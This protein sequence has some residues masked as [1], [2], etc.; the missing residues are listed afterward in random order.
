MRIMCVPHT[1][2]IIASEKYHTVTSSILKCDI[3]AALCRMEIVPKLEVICL[4]WI[5]LKSTEVHSEHK[6]QRDKY[7]SKY[8]KQ[9]E[10]QLILRRKDLALGMEGHR[11]KT[12]TDSN[13]AQAEAIERTPKCFF[14]C[15]WMSLD[16]L[17]V[18]TQPIII[19]MSKRRKPQSPQ[20]NPCMLKPFL[21]YVQLTN[22]E[23]AFFHAWWSFRF[24][25]PSHIGQKITVSQ[26]ACDVSYAEAHF[27]CSHCGDQVVIC[28]A[29]MKQSCS[30]WVVTL[31]SGNWR[32]ENVAL[33]I[34]ENVA[35]E[36]REDIFFFIFDPLYIH[37]NEL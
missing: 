31:L 4:T 18:A 37:L 1:G 34:R 12:N 15:I 9:Q 17:R 27:I 8:V 7:V 6:C 16:V 23:N 30:I 5:L 35:L 28:F 26:S 2:C 36:T 10:E 25:W 14:I 11:I 32:A 33:E 20:K 24:V 21:L 13:F 29:S 19:T 22:N 3:G